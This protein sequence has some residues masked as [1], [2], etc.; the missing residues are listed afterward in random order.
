MSDRRRAHVVA[1]TTLAVI[2]LVGPASAQRKQVTIPFLANASRPTDLD[3]EAAECDVAE[4]GQTMACEFQQV[5]LSVSDIVP[6]TCMIVTNRYELTFRK[7]TPTRWVSNEG[8]TGAC[9]VI[10]VATLQDDGGVRWIKET[11]KVLTNRNGSESCS[12]L[13][14]RPEV[15]SWQQLRR[16]LPCRFIQPAAFVR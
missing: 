10:N 4:D 2:V 3:F 8:P 5:L 15:L 7:Q 16:P 6:E 9:G 11:R 14:E 13:D 12:L 1:A